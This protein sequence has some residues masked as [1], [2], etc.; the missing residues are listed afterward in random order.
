[1]SISG[2]KT[3]PWNCRVTAFLERNQIL[4]LIKGSKSEIPSEKDCKTN[5]DGKIQNSSVIL[6]KNGFYR[7]VLVNW[8]F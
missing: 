3:E 6:E 8:C 1:M 7:S 2:C 4:S 5:A